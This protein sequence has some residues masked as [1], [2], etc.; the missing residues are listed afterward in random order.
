MKEI[1]SFMRPIIQFSASAH[2]NSTYKEYT[3]LSN[4]LKSGTKL[5]QIHDDLMQKETEIGNNQNSSP[6]WEFKSCNHM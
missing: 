5:A 4:Y 6:Q 3:D 2:Y 1:K